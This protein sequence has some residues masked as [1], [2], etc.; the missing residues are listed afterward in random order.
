MN[1]FLKFCGLGPYETFQEFTRHVIPSL[2]LL[3]RIP[4][5]TRI[6]TWVGVLMEEFFYAVVAIVSWLAYGAL[7][8][9]TALASWTRKPR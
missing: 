2:Y 6:F 8:A 9:L 5:V 4:S 1:R 3:L 7:K